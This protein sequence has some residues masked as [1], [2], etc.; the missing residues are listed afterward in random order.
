MT[1]VPT[2]IV[3]GST[4]RTGN[5]WQKN[6]MDEARIVSAKVMIPSSGYHTLKVWMVD[7]GI[8]LQKIFI[9]LGSLKPSYSDLLRVT[10]NVESVPSR[11]G[12]ARINQIKTSRS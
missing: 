11:I 10:T 8:T 4:P 12:E 9:D 5:E 6:V 7:P 3:A 2:T 1:G